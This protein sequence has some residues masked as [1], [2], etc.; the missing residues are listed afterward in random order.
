MMC[1]RRAGLQGGKA[2]G[3]PP[4]WLNAAEKESWL[5][6]A[7][8]L[9]AGV[10]TSMDRAAFEEMA[11]LRVICRKGTARVAERQLY[12]TYLGLFGMSPA[13]RSKVKAEPERQK[14]WSPVD[15]FIQ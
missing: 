7:S 12:K 11:C 13:D 5:Y 4:K 10:A 3:D 6:L 8:L 1:L 14:H 15:E 9:A 2:L